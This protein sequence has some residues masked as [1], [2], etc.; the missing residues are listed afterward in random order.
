MYFLVELVND[1]LVRGRIADVR[2]IV[3]SILVRDCRLAVQRVEL[4]EPELLVV[5]VT[6]I[7]V[8]VI[9]VECH[10]TG[11]AVF[12]VPDLVPRERILLVRDQLLIHGL[13][14]VIKQSQIQTGKYLIFDIRGAPTKPRRQHQSGCGGLLQSSDI[15]HGSSVSVIPGTRVGSEKLSERI[16][17]TV[18]SVRLLARVL[19]IFVA[20]ELYFLASASMAS[21]L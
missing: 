12:G 11:F 19:L 10:G 9:R 5:H 17:I 20:A 14:G 2:R 13:H 6:Q 15:R 3:D 7:H 1:V 4:V 18:L 8:L 21:W 16:V